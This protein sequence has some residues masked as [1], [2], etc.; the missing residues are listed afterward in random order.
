M[1]RLH[2]YL[3]GEILRPFAV[4]LLLMFQLLFALQLLRGTDLVFGA[5]ATAADVGRIALC[6]APHFVAMALP[7]AYLLGV[8]IGLGRLSEDRELLALSAFGLDPAR[9]LIVPLA[10]ALAASA[11][12]VGLGRRIEPMGIQ[13]VRTV[14]GE[15]LRKN[16]QGRVRSGTFFGDLTG[17]TVYAEDVDPGTGA[18]H[19]VL[20]HDDRD[21]RSPLL[22]L[23]QGG[24]LAVG[25]G[26]GVSLLLD[27][28][29]V[30]RAGAKA[31]AYSVMQF[32]HGRIEVDLGKAFL[33]RNKLEANSSEL[34]ASALRAAASRA[35]RGSPAAARLWTELARRLALPM[36][37]LAF[38]LVAVPLATRLRRGARAQG[39][40]LAAAGFALYYVVARLGQQWGNA[41]ALPP[42][43]AAQLA[44]LTFALVGVWLLAAAR[45]RA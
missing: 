29:R 39:F 12:G 24:R 44:N 7:I 36:A 20:V 5:G 13:R 43:L 26:D 15:L 23:A 10:V 30:H 19:H 14:A 37:P 11:V 41:G 18:W 2:L 33:H 1:R 40:G 22:V 25:P 32:E 28:G 16:L 9:L 3:A 6:L 45:R 31:D 27:D 34:T 42:S 35:P 8:L 21:P 4:S 38:A 17:L